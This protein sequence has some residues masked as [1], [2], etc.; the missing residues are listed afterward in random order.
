MELSVE[1][2]GV[3]DPE[4]L[5]TS[6]IEESNCLADAA[7]SGR[8]S[9]VLQLLDSSVRLNVNQWRIGGSSWFTVLH[10]AAWLG[11]PLD[12]VRELLDRGAW[13]SLRNAAGERPVDIARARGHSRLL[14]TLAIRE[15]GEAEQ[16]KFAAWDLHLAELIAEQTRRLPPVAFREVPTEVI[17]LEGLE[18][19]WFAYPGMYGGFSLSIYKDRR[20]VESWSRVVAGSGQ[21]H[22]ITESGCA[23]VEEGFV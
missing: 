6:Y 7:K 23:L 21:A 2:P 20:F 4:V 1:W 8:W 11:A 3:L 19:L 22:V 14:N 10:Q 15:P 12:V 13:R 9:E 17:A 16:R 5:Q 18:D